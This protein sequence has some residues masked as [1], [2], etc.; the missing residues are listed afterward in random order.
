MSLEKL[1]ADFG[2]DVSYIIPLIKRNCYY[3][4]IKF[5]CLEFDIHPDNIL[6]RKE[7]NLLAKKFVCYYLTLY[8]KKITQAEIGDMLQMQQGNVS[9]AVY[10]I[11]NLINADFSMRAR[12]HRMK[13]KIMY[14]IHE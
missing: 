8:M 1:K 3:C 14:Y 11:K 9:K 7:P 13:T 2:A 6:D 10:D 5:V 4:I 12:H